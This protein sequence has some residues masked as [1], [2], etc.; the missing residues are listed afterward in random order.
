M[1]WHRIDKQ[2]LDAFSAAHPDHPL[3]LDIDH[4]D[5]QCDGRGDMVSIDARDA[6]GNPVALSQP[7]P[8]ALSAFLERGG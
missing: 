7:I 8:P 3:P 1:A 6:A 4:V 2:A 5:V